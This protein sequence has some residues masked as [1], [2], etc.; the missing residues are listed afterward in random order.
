MANT[1]P[2]L[3]YANTFSDWYVVTN[4]LSQENNILAKGDYTKDSGTL[5]LSETTQNSLQSNGNIVVQKQ[6]L[7]EGL[8]SSATVQNNLTVGGQVYFTNSTLRIF[9]SIVRATCPVLFSD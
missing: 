5:Y 6:L 8:G 1:V 9:L 4:A 3:S 2:I 7:V